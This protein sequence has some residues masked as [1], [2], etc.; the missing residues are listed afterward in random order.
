VADL[1]VLL[2]GNAAAASVLLNAGV[3]KLVS[4]VPLGRALREVLPAHRQVLD[5]LARSGAIGRFAGVAE[6]IAALGLLPATTRMPAAI[7]TAVLGGAF[8]ALGTA[9]LLRRSVKPCGCFGMA[10]N[11]RLGAT[12]IVVGLALVLLAPLNAVA[13]AA[14]GS[15]AGYEQ[16]IVMLTSLGAL[17]LCLWLHRR[18]ARNAWNLMR[19]IRQR[20]EVQ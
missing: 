16:A 5:R 9:G 18:A 20:G 4:P 8:A 19:T 2:A 15:E 14:A 1:I 13:T 12:N 7:A 6:V 17:L 3:A 11:Q 10:S